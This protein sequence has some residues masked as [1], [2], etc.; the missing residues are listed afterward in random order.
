MSAIFRTA[1]QT[2]A[3]LDFRPN[4]FRHL[5]RRFIHRLCI[6][7]CA[8]RTGT[9]GEPIAVLI[10]NGR[11][12]QHRNVG[13]ADAHG[14][15]VEFSIFLGH[16]N[17][18]QNIAVLGAFGVLG[19][20]HN[21]ALVQ[22]YLCVQHEEHGQHIGKAE[23]AVQAAADGRQIAKLHADNVAHGF[24]H[25]TVRVGC[26]SFVQLQRAQ[27][28]HRTDPELG[29]GL[30]DGVQSQTGQVDCR[31]D[32]QRLHL[33][34]DHAADHAVGLFLVERIR[35]LERLGFFVF[36]Y[37]QHTLYPLSFRGMCYLFSILLLFYHKIC[38]NAVVNIKIQRKEK[39]VGKEPPCSQISA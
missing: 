37:R 9:D 30:L 28:G 17:A 2:A 22:L 7:L 12:G 38:Y 29:F 20:R 5:L 25:S 18:H 1:A 31:A 24:A 26:Q 15:V 32:I 39:V 14:L 8:R 35:F 23:P 6:N 16:D 27:R 13:L 21:A 36:P 19:K 11:A 4:G 3:G 33:E 34:P 10:L